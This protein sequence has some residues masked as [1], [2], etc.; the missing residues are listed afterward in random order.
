MISPMFEAAF[1][2]TRFKKLTFLLILGKKGV[3]WW[4]GKGEPI[5]GR[6]EMLDLSLGGRNETALERQGRQDRRKWKFIVCYLLL[7]FPLNFVTYI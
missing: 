5:N 1:Q 3:E 7:W 2:Q 4:D 6:G